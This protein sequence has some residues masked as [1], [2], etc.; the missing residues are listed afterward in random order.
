MQIFKNVYRSDQAYNYIAENNPE[1][2]E[3]LVKFICLNETN[4]EIIFEG[5]TALEELL[6][7]PTFISGIP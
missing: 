3:L 4:G 1:T 5:L 2:G 7:R 6:R